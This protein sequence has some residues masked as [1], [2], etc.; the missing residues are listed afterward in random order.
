MDADPFRSSPLA[1]RARLHG[2]RRDGAFKTTTR[3][4]GGGEWGSGMIRLAPRAK[5][6]GSPV[7]ESRLDFFEE[8][9]AA[10]GRRMIHVVMGEIIETGAGRADPAQRARQ[11]AAGRIAHHEG[12][13]S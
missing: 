1:A 6:S 10:L 13:Y 8:S 7:R 2:F 4:R 3:D 9:F 5:F 11:E 12:Q